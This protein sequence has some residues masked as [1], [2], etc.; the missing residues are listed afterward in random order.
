METPDEFF[1]RPRTP[2]TPEEFERRRKAAEAIRALR[3]DIRPMT[4]TELR[5]LAREDWV[6]DDEDAGG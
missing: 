3:V 1:E 6:Y 4:V 2:P 5:R